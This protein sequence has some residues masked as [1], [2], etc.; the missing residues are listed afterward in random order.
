MVEERWSCKLVRKR[1]SSRKLVW[2]LVRQRW[3]CK[4]EPGEA[5][6]VGEEAW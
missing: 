4:L 2:K 3:S 1:W 5:E 6:V